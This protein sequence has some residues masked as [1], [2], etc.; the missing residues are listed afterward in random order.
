MLIITCIIN[1]SLGN[2]NKEFTSKME[3]ITKKN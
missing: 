3:T 2:N 1:S